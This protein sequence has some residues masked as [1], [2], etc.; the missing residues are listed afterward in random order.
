MTGVS[1]RPDSP[2][3]EGLRGMKRPL[4]RDVFAMLQMSLYERR[5]LCRHVM[6]FG[7]ECVPCHV[8]VLRSL[9]LS[10]N[11]PSHS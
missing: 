10:C 9:N 8:I 6:W 7:N 11:K 1:M 4:S 2:W 5:T 3:Q